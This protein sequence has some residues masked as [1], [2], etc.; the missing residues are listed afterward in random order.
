MVWICN[1]LLA[2]WVAINVLGYLVV[3][4]DKKAAASRRKRPRVPERSFHF[5]GLFGA[6]LGPL[7]AFFAYRHKTR[8]KGFM[9]RFVAAAVFGWTLL[10]AWL[11]A[12]C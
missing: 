11:W 7:I 10:A 9:T 4:H 5:F 8:K 6:G 1:V 3:R 2:V 12:I